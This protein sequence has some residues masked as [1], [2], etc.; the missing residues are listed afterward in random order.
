MRLFFL[1]VL[2]SLS[3]CGKFTEKF[4][5]LSGEETAVRF[6]VEGMNG[7]TAAL[8][9]VMVY[10]VRSSD[11]R[12]RGAKYFTSESATDVDW[13]IPNGV[14]NFYALGYTGANMTG[15]MKC[16]RANLISLAGGS[17]Q[18]AIEMT[19]T[20]Q[21]GTPPFSPAG[22]GVASTDSPRTLFLGFCASS[23]G[24]I[25]ITDAFANDCDGLSSRPAAGSA[26]SIKIRIEEY[27]KWDPNQQ[28]VGLSGGISSACAAGVYVGSPV[29][30]ILTPPYGSPFV[31]TIFAYSDGACSTYLSSYTFTGGV[32]NGADNSTM[33]F[34]DSSG[35][36]VSPPLQAI[37]PHSASV[38]VYMYL[39]NL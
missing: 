36:R 9:G 5:R 10:A 1:F 11:D 4:G 27:A 3:S 18:V 26:S 33:R 35:V 19:H 14:Y 32:I 34:H 31:I 2:F 20:G 17:Q 6:S 38:N 21:C 12:S 37:M 22:Y 24:D 39:R 15:A 13:M 23:G 29:T 16:G 8:A 30:T 25:S 28:G 7:P